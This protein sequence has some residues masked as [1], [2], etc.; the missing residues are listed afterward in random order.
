MGH[1]EMSADFRRPTRHFDSFPAEVREWLLGLAK[2]GEAIVTSFDEK[3]STVILIRRNGRPRALARWQTVE[4]RILSFPPRARPGLVHDRKRGVLAVRARPPGP[5]DRRLSR[6]AERTL[7]AGAALAG[8]N[9]DTCYSLEPLRNGTFNWDGNEKVGAVALTS[10][11][12]R[13]PGATEGYLTVISGDVRRTLSEEIPLFPL[14]G[15]DLVH[16]RFRFTIAVGGDDARV[17]VTVKPPWLSDLHL[18]PHR[19]VIGE[20][21][22]E[23]GVMLA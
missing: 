5:R 21:L 6:R 7:L 18:K 16:A 14:E 17:S 19:D 4:L 9:P 20:F 11:C 10:V 2:S 22:R 15:G 12:L 23:Q 13:V 8:W 1:H 3:D